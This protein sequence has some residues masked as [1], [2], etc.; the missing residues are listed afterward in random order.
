[1][2]LDTASSVMSCAPVRAKSDRTRR[3]TYIGPNAKA[4]DQTSPEA[5]KP[6]EAHR[7]PLL[8]GRSLPAPRRCSREL[9][10]SPRALSQSQRGSCDLL[11]RSVLCRQKLHR[12]RVRTP[13]QCI[14]EVPATSLVPSGP[15]SL[16]PLAG[17]D[18]ERRRFLYGP[19]RFRTGGRSGS[20]RTVSVA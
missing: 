20:H 14:H 15:P 9:S 6:H 16:S 19:L 2:G 5:G 10:V 8:R 4:L 13:R 7:S 1:M 18:F 3:P 11:L 17:V 12:V